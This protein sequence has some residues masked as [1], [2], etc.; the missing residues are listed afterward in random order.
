MM[1]PLFL[2]IRSFVVLIAG[3]VLAV[4][5]L[6]SSVSRV[7]ASA[8]S[9]VAVSD[10]CTGPLQTAP[11][12]APTGFSHRSAVVDRVQL[13]Y[14]IGGHGD[15]VVV[16]LHGWPENWFEWA[17]IMPE[18]ARGH[19]V[20]AIDLPGLGDSQ[21][22]PP[23][24]DKKTLA[25]Y[26]HRLVADTLGYRHVHLVGHDFGAGVAFAYAA[27]YRD[28][29]TS[30][31]MIDFPLAGPA[32]N[33]Q[34]L[35][36]LLWWFGFHDVAQLPEQLVNNRQRTYL[37]W[38]Y[39]NLVLPPNRIEPEAV[40]EYVRTYCHPSVLHGGFELYRTIAV[41]TSDNSTL[42]S[43]KLML[44]ILVLSPARSNDPDA[45]KQQLLSIIQPMAAGPITVELVPQ[46]GHFVPEE[47]PEFVITQLRLFIEP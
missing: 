36:A 38:F 22:T 10:E 19:T 45:E 41:D 1:R 47:N 2:P 16:L 7:E 44:P 35:R 6:S 46:S 11:A 37:S 21:G 24:Y 14:V 42:T 13:H 4:S 30:L 27:F 43:N 34:Q 9:G 29:A 33:E 18:L 17:E 15:Q 26:V 25:G 23:S 39:D 32:T 28:S 3:F 40:T 8:T 5:T 20:L 12:A 31:T